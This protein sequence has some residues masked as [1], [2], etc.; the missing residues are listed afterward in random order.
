MKKLLAL[1]MVL[2]LAL[3]TVGCDSADDDDTGTGGDP[4][5]IH[6][7]WVSTGNNIAPGLAAFGISQI[8]ATFNANGTYTV[9]ATIAGS[10]FAQTGTYTTQAS[11]VGD[12][13]TIRL[14]QQTPNQLV[15]QGIYE[16][17]GNTMRYEVV[18]V[19]QGTPPTPQG[20][21]GSTVAGDDPAGNWTQ[22]FVRQ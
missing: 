15:A 1:S 21:F 16:V 9:N 11:T 12:I 2:F 7:T 10:Q 18:D 5:A 3:F 22:V 17:E 6:G 20:G 14:E 19:S 8:E 13:R 4:T